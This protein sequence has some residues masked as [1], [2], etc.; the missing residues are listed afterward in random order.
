M[1][2]KNVHAVELGRKGG[3]VGGLS[4]SPAKVAAG[5]Q[6]AAKARAAYQE[7]LAFQKK[8][9]RVKESA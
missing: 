5:R 1:S 4:R 9:R 7:W 6:N 3:K 8:S 2:R